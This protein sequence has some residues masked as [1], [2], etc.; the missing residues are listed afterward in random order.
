MGSVLVLVALGVALATTVVQRA[1][2]RIM[3]WV[4]ELGALLLIAVGGYLTWYWIAVLLR[5][6]HVHTA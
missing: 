4:E 3:P 1:L 6:P 2:R 5:Q